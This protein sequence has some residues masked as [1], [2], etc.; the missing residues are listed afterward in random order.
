[1]DEQQQAL[2]ALDHIVKN[3]QRD[4]EDLK[5]LNQAVS[6]QDES[7][8][9]VFSP[10]MLTVINILSVLLLA[11]SQCLLAGTHVKTPLSYLRLFEFRH[12]FLLGCFRLGCRKYQHFGTY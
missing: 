5:T 4:T 3:P 8:R 6:L 12:C 2:E 1:M 10:R 11:I 9:I 7:E